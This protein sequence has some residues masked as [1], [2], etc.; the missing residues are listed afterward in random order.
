MYSVRSIR[1]CSVVS[2]RLRGLL[3]YHYWQS[4]SIQAFPD[5]FKA[6]SRWALLSVKRALESV[7][8]GLAIRESSKQCV[9]FVEIFSAA[10]GFK[11]NL[12]S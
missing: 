3:K 11:G 7:E 5:V 2:R 9:S 8:Q 12:G 10:K 4:W 6:P 1:R